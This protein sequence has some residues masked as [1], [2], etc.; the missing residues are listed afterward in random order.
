VIPTVVAFAADRRLNQDRTGLPQAETMIAVDP[1]DPLHLVATWIDLDAPRGQNNAIFHAVT[2][3][4]GTTWQTAETLAPGGPGPVAYY[5]IDP[6]VT[7]DGLGNV[8]QAFVTA[9]ILDKSMWVLR[10][11]DG[12]L[13]FAGATSLDPYPSDKPWIVADPVNGNVYVMWTLIGTGIRFSR[14]TDHGVT[15]STPVMLTN[16]AIMGTLDVGPGGEVYV[17]YLTALAIRMDR[18]LNAGVTWLSS[19]PIVAAPITQPPNA[20]GGV[21]NR[22]VIDMAVDRTGGAFAGRIYVAWPDARDGDSDIYLTHSS[23]QGA[24]WST[25]IRVNDDIPGGGTDQINSS[26]WVDDV[27]HVHVQFLDRRLDP[28]NLDFAV[29]LAT[30]TDGGATFARNVRISEPRVPQGGLPGRPNTFLGDYGG[31]DG[32]GGANHVVWSDGRFGDLDIFYRRVDDAD[33]DEDGVLNDG[34]GNGHYT[35]AF[36]TGGQVVSC[37]D[38]CPG[39]INPAQADTDGDL[40][41]DA[42]DNCPTTSNTNQYDLDRDAVGDG[43]DPCPGSAGRPAGDPDGDGQP[44][45]TDNCPGVAN[46]GQADV[47]MDGIGDDCDPCP[48]D[49][50]NDQD[51]DGLCESADNCATTWNA[52]QIDGDGDGAG[53]LCDVCPSQPDP[54][55]TDSDGDGRGDLCDCEPSE[56]LD[57]GYAGDLAPR[58]IEALRA[59]KVGTTASFGWVGPGVEGPG[60]GPRQG[61]PGFGFDAFSVSR[62]LLSTLR[63]T[64]S[65]GACFVEG[66]KRGFED[67]ALPPAGDGYVYLAQGQNFDCGMG[68]LGFTSAELPR[69]NTDPLACAGHPFSDIVAASE[70]PISGSVSGTI[71]DM[72]VSDDSYESIR[73]VGQ[74]GF[75]HLEHRWSYNVPAGAGLVEV[76]SESFWTPSANQEPIRLE[77]S[78]DGG[79]SFSHLLNFDDTTDQ[80]RDWVVTIPPFAGVLILRV[81]DSLSVQADR[82]EISIDKLWIRAVP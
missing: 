7:L 27:G 23:D 11:T 63:S 39:A 61:M 3:D 29:Y 24:T 40:V 12:G 77:V 46:A 37:D 31:G 62:G 26:V 71:D 41:G 43:C 60:G 45:C 34:D 14:S 16:N 22:M 73:E 54:A 49:V 55:Q 78:T 80:D 28:S 13:T 52:R 10:S 47:D 2:F 35:G 69:A 53:N 8:F 17:V 44:E 4:G 32:A 79:A 30:S 51:G 68:S 20:N 38:N 64:G 67:V 6:A 66:V 19:D 81:K 50:G 25:P 65:F 75:S 70:T 82:E 15:F 5:R 1:S 36:C 74:G 72:R 56:Q 76:H 58:D 18:S 9:G 48:I 21:W 57:T 59:F 33:F 42:C